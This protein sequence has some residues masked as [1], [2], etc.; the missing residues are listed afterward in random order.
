MCVVVRSLSQWNTVD[1]FV[2]HLPNSFL[3]KILIQ[4]MHRL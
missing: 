4:P 3:I 1:V 2:Q